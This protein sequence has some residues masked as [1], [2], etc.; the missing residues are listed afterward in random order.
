MKAKN[1]LF[2]WSI[3][4]KVE[5]KNVMFWSQNDSSK[6]KNTLLQ[7]ILQK[8]FEIQTFQRIAKFIMVNSYKMDFTKGNV[9][10]VKV[11]EMYNILKSVGH[12]SF[13]ER[14][15]W[16]WMIRFFAKVC[17]WMSIRL[18]RPSFIK[19][20]ASSCKRYSCRER[21]WYLQYMY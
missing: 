2:V 21:V 3:S 18:L 12:S 20:Q 11:D 8:V 10:L 4:I 5:T 7:W 1:K 17:S 16:N 15:R 9:V 19:E 13:V 6:V 14:W